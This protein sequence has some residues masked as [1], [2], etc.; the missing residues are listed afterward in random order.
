MSLKICFVVKLLKILSEITF[1]YKFKKV[2]R[3]WGINFINYL[4]F[5]SSCGARGIVVVCVV[6][7]CDVVAEV[8]AKTWLPWLLLPLEW[9]PR[10]TTTPLSW[11]TPMCGALRKQL[12]TQPSASRGNTNSLTLL[13]LASH[14]AN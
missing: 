10:L 1:S 7:G 13:V 12:T 2:S 5:C 8:H 9:W 14:F 6:D 4:R 3:D 11:R